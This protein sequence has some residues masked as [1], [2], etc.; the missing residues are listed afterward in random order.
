MGVIIQCLIV[1]KLSESAINYFIELSIFSTDGLT[2]EDQ[3]RFIHIKPR[4]HQSS[5]FPCPC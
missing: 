4:P 5:V 1:S 2:Q 3:G